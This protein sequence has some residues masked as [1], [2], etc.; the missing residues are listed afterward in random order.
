MHT[1]V[2]QVTIVFHIKVIMCRIKAT[3]HFHIFFQPL[4]KLLCVMMV[5]LHPHPNRY[6]IKFVVG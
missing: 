1:C 3:H 6:L 2:Y 4:G 5:T